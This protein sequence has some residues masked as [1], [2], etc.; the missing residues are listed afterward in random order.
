MAKQGSALKPPTH[1]PSHAVRDPASLAPGPAALAEVASAMH[2]ATGSLARAAR[3]DLDAIGTAAAAGRLYVTTRSLPELKYDVP[4]PYAQ[5]PRDRVAGALAVYADT[6][7][8]SQAALRSAADVAAAVDAPSRVLSAAEQ[9]TA[10]QVALPRGRLEQNLLD[11]GVRDPEMLRRGGDLDEMAQRVL[12]QAHRSGPASPQ[13]DAEVAPEP[14]AA[15]AAAEAARPAEAAA[16]EPVIH[17]P[18]A[19]PS[20]KPSWRAGDAQY[21]SAVAEPGASL[22]ALQIGGEEPELEL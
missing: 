15:D 4:R 6:A 11:L 22:D 5:A 3:T 19:E 12:A 20:L 16:S 17:E 8:I 13:P 1:R 7:G 9:A 14:D 21:P 2:Y 10:D 18:G